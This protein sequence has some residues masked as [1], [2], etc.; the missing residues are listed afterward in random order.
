MPQ[1]PLLLRSG[2]TRQPKFK[3]GS[4][5]GDPGEVGLHISL[6]PRVSMGPRGR[7][8]PAFPGITG[9]STRQMRSAAS[10]HLGAQ[11][12]KLGLQ[13]WSIPRTMGVGVL[14]G[15]TVFV[16]CSVRIGLSGDGRGSVGCGGSSVAV[17]PKSGGKGSLP[18]SVVSISMHRP[19][20][21]GIIGG[22]M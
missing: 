1:A 17:G 18:S 3:A 15:W 11:G 7:Q 10:S 13:T 20:L 22:S 5:M 16:G 21:P 2:S 4:Q 9:G 14:V 8:V 6:G 19:A 12:P